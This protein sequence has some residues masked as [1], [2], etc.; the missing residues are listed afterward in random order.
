MKLL[1]ARSVARSNFDFASFKFARACC[2][3]A[4]LI[5]GSSRTSVAPLATRC[6]SLK[7]IALMRPATSGRRGMDSSE[8]RLPT[9]VIVCGKA[10]RPTLM[11]STTTPPGAAPRGSAALRGRAGCGTVVRR[12]GRALLAEP[13]ASARGDRDH[14]H[15]CSAGSR[16]VH[17]HASVSKSCQKGQLC[18]GALRP[19]K[20]AP[21]ALLECEGVCRIGKICDESAVSNYWHRTGGCLCRVRHSPNDPCAGVPHKDRPTRRSVPAR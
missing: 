6:P 1:L 11:A 20:Q 9:A 2:V 13:E 7:R 8:R 4:S 3:S 21:G 18:A 16:L 12:R 17:G 10:M 19:G 5:D 14:E 15:R